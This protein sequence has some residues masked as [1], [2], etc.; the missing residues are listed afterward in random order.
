MASRHTSVIPICLMGAL[1]LDGCGVNGRVEQGRVVAYDPQSNRLTLI[2]ETVPPR[3][4]TIT[5]PADPAEIGPPPTAG[6]LLSLDYRNH[7]I[8]IYDRATGAFK[9][10]AYRPLKERFHVAKAPKV[11]AVDPA[12]KTITIYDAANHALITFAATGDLLALPADTWR[13]GDII[14]YYCKDPAHAL[15]LMNVSKTDLSK[16]S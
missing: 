15:R 4:V 2:L 16:S 9:T 10:I 6:G 7:R 12:R 14:R 3:P 5:A 1:L 8:A 13:A 11:P